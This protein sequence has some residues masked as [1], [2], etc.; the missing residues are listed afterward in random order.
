MKIYNSIN[1]LIGIGSLNGNE[2]INGDC[3]EVMKYIPDKSIDMIL[4]DP[5]YGTTCLKWDKV[6]NFDVLWQEYKRIIKD[7]GIIVLFGIQPF[8]TMLIASNLEMYRYSWLWKKNTATGFLN[9]NY[10]PLNIT[11]DIC[12]FS[13]GTIGSLSKNPITY[14]PQGIVEVNIK[15]KNNPNSNWR[16]NKGYDS[17]NNVLN[18]DKEFTQKYTG[19]PNNILDFDRDKPSVHPTQKPVALLEYL[20]NTYTNENDL[21]LDN[22]MGSG[23]TGVACLHTNRNFIGIELDKKYFQVAKERIEREA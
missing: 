22:C 14:Y 10:K 8:T 11:E 21:V 4:C 12:V 3:L 9:A 23:S 17:M 1:D 6:I 13:F 7:N 15:K 19:Y 20:I 16:K 2:L 5:P 18:S